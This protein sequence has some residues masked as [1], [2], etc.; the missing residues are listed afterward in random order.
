[1]TAIF[2]AVADALL[3]GAFWVLMYLALLVSEQYRYTFDAR[4]RA[5][6]TFAVVGLVAFALLALW[7]SQ[8]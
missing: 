5:E 2:A 7:G 8:I 3:I 4:A 1:M 6:I